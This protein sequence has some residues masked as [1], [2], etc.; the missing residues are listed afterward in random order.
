VPGYSA[1]LHPVGDGL[2]LGVGQDATPE[3]RRTGV[4]LSLFDVS[5]LA[6]PVRLDRYAVGANSWSAVENDHHAFLWW[7]PSKLAVVPAVR[8][9]FEN[10]ASDF[11]GSIA[12]HV[13]R[14]GGIT[15]AARI[16]HPALDEFFE[17]S[18]DRAA[19]VGSRLLLLS[20]AGVLSTFVGAPG[21]GQFVR[22][23]KG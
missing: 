16:A 18:Y 14:A 22:Y 19:V 23:E 20:Q 8:Y 10:G 2:L 15:E 11:A 6:R 7:E 1:Y 21:P 4:Q 12:L 5:D 13:D 9:D 3:G 17:L